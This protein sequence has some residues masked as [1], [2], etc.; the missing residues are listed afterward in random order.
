MAGVPAKTLSGSTKVPTA[1]DATQSLL[2]RRAEWREP[3]A[4]PGLSY[5]GVLEAQDSF[6]L[7]GDR[8]G[9]LGL[10]ALSGAWIISVNKYSALHR[11]PI[12]SWTCHDTCT[13]DEAGSG[14]GLLCCRQRDG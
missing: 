8:F 3:A 6:N 14:R 2:S 7:I 11:A 13:Q 10:S 9:V 5:R 4:P 1:H 12:S